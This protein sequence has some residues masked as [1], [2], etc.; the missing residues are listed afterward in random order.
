MSLECPALSGANKVVNKHELSWIGFAKM[1]ENKES[2]QEF[3]GLKFN[4]VTDDSRLSHIRD[5][6][7]FIH[8]YARLICNGDWDSDIITR[9]PKISSQRTHADSVREKE[10]AGKK[11]TAGRKEDLTPS[12][13]QLFNS[14]QQMS[15]I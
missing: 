7:Q 15:D 11:E 5:Q 10:T 12:H 2:G 9:E 8:H 4:G 3:T 1:F 6:N 14:H 13:K